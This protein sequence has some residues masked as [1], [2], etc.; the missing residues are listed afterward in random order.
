MELNRD[1]ENKWIFQKNINSNEL[2]KLYLNALK[3]QDNKINYE[4]SLK[5]LKEINGY[6]GRSSNGTTNTLGVRM[7]Q[8]CFY[9]LGYKT[10][11]KEFIPSV[12]SQIYE[13]DNSKKDIVFLINLF[14]LQFPNPYS[15]TPT[16]FKIYIG[17][18]ILKLLLEE[19]IEK[20]IY[21]DEFIWF[22]PFIE[23]I[24]EDIY[25]NLISEIL[26]YRGKTY[27]EKLKLF[28]GIKNYNSLFANVLHECLYYLLEFLKVLMF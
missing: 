5:Y 18:L 22:L 21:I 3:K 10:Y 19:R 9:M 24:N 7:S 17:R 25:E 14:S 13:K 11:N 28:S 15:K 16:N 12:S 4:I 27:E 23:K 8:M 2:I 20:R 26:K 1:K 6:K